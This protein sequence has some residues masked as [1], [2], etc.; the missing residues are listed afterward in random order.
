M[1][2]GFPRKGMCQD[3]VSHSVHTTGYGIE[4]E[5]APQDEIVSPF[6]F[7]SQMKVSPQ[8]ELEFLEGSGNHK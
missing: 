7:D 3:L 8:R 5:I 6:Q 2:S 1:N 4:F